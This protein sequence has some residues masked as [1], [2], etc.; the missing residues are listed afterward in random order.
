VQP[1]EID[2]VIMG[3]YCVF[4]LVDRK[5]LRYGESCEYLAIRRH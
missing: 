2:W 4:V 5:A 3:V 1:S